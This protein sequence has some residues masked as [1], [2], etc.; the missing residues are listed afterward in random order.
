MAPAYSL[1]SPA[2]TSGSTAAGAV[3]QG[4]DS[5]VSVIIPMY[6]AADTI[7][8]A[9]RSVQA[10]TLPA[11]E[12]VVVDDGST[13]GSADVVMGVPG[14]RVVSKENGGTASARN[15]GCGAASCEWIKYLDSDDILYPNCLE[16]LMGVNAALDPS[17][18]VVPVMSER[19][20]YPDGTEWLAGYDCNHMT[21]LEQG[22]RQLDHF[23]GGT[24]ESILRRSVVA[25][26]GGFDER[27]RFAEDYEFV[28]RL[29]VA[30]KY[31]FWHI[32]RLVCEYRVRP[33]SQSSVDPAFGKRAVDG[34]A[35]SVLDS[36]DRGERSR[37]L[38]ALRRYRG[39]RA[40]VGGVHAFAN[41][42][43]AYMP[44]RSSYRNAAH[45]A[46][47]GMLRSCRPLHDFYR[48]MRSAG[49]AGSLR[50][51]WGWAWAARH[52]S[53]DL[54]ARCRGLH[55]NGLNAATPP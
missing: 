31:R 36:L 46:A 47:A 22:A 50:H 5:G 43:H 51:L 30:H 2:K 23:I 55:P 48:G 34:I 11:R 52:P 49:R 1:P 12:I 27:L 35:R 7:M 9:V 15:A 29:L 16:D 20:V 39:R 40:F 17:A 44:D 25:G 13:D 19:I 37:Y 14:V 41:S 18:R 45:A 26:I 8:D 32:P 10:Q 38:S 4:V 54:V 24:H 42:R 53:H 33:G 21:T 3:G 6:N 28:L